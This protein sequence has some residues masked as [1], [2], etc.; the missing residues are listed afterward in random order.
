MKKRRILSAALI[1]L[2]VCLPCARPALAEDEG[3]PA[4]SLVK[5]LSS[6]PHLVTGGDALLAVAIPPGRSAADIRVI[7]NGET[8][9]GLFQADRQAGRLVGLVTDLPL[10]DSV[11]K[12]EVLAGTG[13]FEE[14]TLTNHRVNGPLISGPHLSPFVC[15]TEQF[16]LPD[17]STL[18]PALDEDC[19]VAP[20]VAH[21]YLAEG[22]DRFSPLADPG[23]LPADVARVTTRSG[24]TMPFVVRLETRVINR[25]IYQSAVL[26]DPTAERDPN[27]FAPP[28]G[29]N[30]GVIA[31]HGFGCVS[32]WYRQGDAQGAD[33]L[34]S[35]RLGEGYALFTNTLNHPTNSC[36]PVLAGETA[37]MGKERLIETLGEPAYTVSIGSSGGAYTSLQIADAFPGLFDGVLIGSTFPDALSIALAGLDAHLLSNYY[38]KNNNGN[39]SEAQMVAVSGFKSARAWYDMAMQSGRADPVPGREDPLPASDY[40]KGYRSAVWHEAVPETLRYHP[41]S[42]PRGARPTVFD[43]ARNVYGSDPATGFARRPYDNVGVQ[44]GLRALEAGIITPAQFVDLNARIGSFDLDGNPVK[45]RSVAGDE[46]LRRTYRSGISLGGG[47][48]LAAIP[49][50]DLSHLYDEDQLY[51]YQWFHFAVRERMRAHNGH[52]NNH[53]MWRGGYPVADGL[54]SKSSP[55]AAALKALVEADSWALFIDWVRAYKADRSPD[56]QVDKVIRHKPPGA[57][58]GC[59]TWSTAP[60]FIP[61]PQTFGRDEHARCNRLWPSWS[62]VRREAGGPLHANILKCQLKPLSRRDYPVTFSD[63]DWRRLAAVFPGGV[64]DWSRPGVEQQPVIPW[65]SL[66]PVPIG[67]TGAR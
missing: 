66:G 17:G 8:I 13:L 34:D 49:V 11:V 28:R 47:G 37:A 43:A 62:F 58:D 51:H 1:A 65:H 42:N 30:G 2:I 67:L 56:P 23:V 16:R 60:D 45:G 33:I 36:N 61:E 15:Q 19:S 50:F 48:G 27:P 7:L 64:C 40:L 4:G 63:R 38:L 35:Q 41:D 57:V 10:G 31:V 18:G 29:W 46:V 9:T 26:H 21:V 5:V 14:L 12:A 20:R 59:F 3:P 39:F 53:V 6:Q 52:A 44:Y 22:A 25:G 24:I 32:G 54:G 55:E